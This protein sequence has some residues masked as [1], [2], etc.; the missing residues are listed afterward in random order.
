MTVE[1]LFNMYLETLDSEHDE[2]YYI[3]DRDLHSIGIE[4][5]L[6]WMKDQTYEIKIE[7]V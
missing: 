5:F 6:E 7:R 3:D 1:D 4:G 2:E